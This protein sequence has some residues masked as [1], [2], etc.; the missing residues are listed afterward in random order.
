MDDSEGRPGAGTPPVPPV[1]S[2][3]RPGTVAFLLMAAGRRLR[4]EVEAALAA[5]GSSL[6]H[7]SALGH[8]SREPGLS[9]SELGRRAGVT[10]QSMQATV[11]RLEELGAIERRTAPGRGRTA[12]LHVTD[13]GRRM[14]E[15]GHRAVADAE[16]RLLGTVPA[17][18]AAAVADLLLPLL[19]PR[20]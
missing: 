14:V 6:R 15:A 12:D 2:P 18:L 7:V 5:D 19:D 3:D 17:E 13:T 16:E 10:A 8:L 20:R 4:A 9:Y 11:R 1:P